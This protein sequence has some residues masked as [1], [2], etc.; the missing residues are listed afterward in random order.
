MI[1]KGGFA[2]IHLNNNK[3]IALIMVLLMVLVVGV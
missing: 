2:M 3:G 1:K